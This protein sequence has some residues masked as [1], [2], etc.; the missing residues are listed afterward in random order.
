MIQNM[1]KTKNGRVIP[2]KRDGDFFLRLGSQRLE[3]NNLIDAIKHYHKA[4][5]MEPEN[6]DARLAIAE[7]LTEMHRYE[8]SNQLLFPLLSSDESPAECFFGIACNFLGLQEFSHAQD[9][10]ESYLALDPEGE[11]V[12]DALDM[13]DIIEDKQTLYN[14]PGVQPPDMREAINAC[15][16]GRRLLEFGSIKEAIELLRE[17]VEKWPDK[18]F[19]KN[20]LALAYFCDKNHNDAMS[21][22]SDVLDVEPND[23]QAHC[24]MLLFL[25]SEGD[26]DGLKRELEFLSNVKTEDPQDWSRMSIVLLETG[27]IEK[28]LSIL[29]R[30][31]S[32]FP[33]DEGTL[34]R[35]AICYYKQGRFITARACYDK[36][37]KINPDDTV[38]AFYRR[39]CHKAAEGEMEKV[40][41][42]Y[43]YEVPYVEVLRRVR[44]IN[45]ASRTQKEDLVR[46]W[47][48][49]EYFRALLNW[50]LR[51]PDV[52]AKRVLLGM[53]AC[54]K[55]K[56]SE[57]MLRHFQLDQMQPD[58]VKQDVF[59][60]LK[61][62]GAKEPYIAYLDGRLVQSRVS[63]RSVVH[64]SLPK[65]Y[66]RALEICTRNMQDLRANNT[67]IEAVD[68]FQQYINT[69]SHIPQ[70][71][72]LQVHAFAAALDYIASK[73]KGEDV[74][75]TKIASQ[76][77]VT[78]V[79]L[80]NAVTKIQR[81]LSG[82]HHDE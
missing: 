15:A 18:L 57:N 1:Q 58:E 23:V 76:Y 79:R 35:L 38:A 32:A 9:S 66:Q 48:N 16:R 42:L 51:L 5:E 73:N 74:S 13:L 46:R 75:K 40:D 49:D 62:M 34:H 50:S 36:L 54:F 20:N 67:L 63:V 82:K 55:D 65:S 45:E 26:E 25:H 8:Q 2:F 71:K 19:I 64:G 31:Q 47:E 37:L 72:G 11:F 24:N 4:I 17:A 41:W 7:V 14:M 21:V 61:H 3:R 12:S 33:Y 70:L 59:A 78:L 30:L 69:A 27:E 43:H 10:L 28:A 52:N 22:V 81:V 60:M 56:Y 53:V 77:G 44:L 29:N 6:V 39:L 80:K 68:I